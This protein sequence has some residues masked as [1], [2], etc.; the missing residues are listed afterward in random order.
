MKKMVSLKCMWCVLPLCILF[1]VTGLTSCSSDPDTDTESVWVF[2]PFFKPAKTKNATEHKTRVELIAKEELPD[3]LITIVNN[4][5]EVFSSTAVFTTQ[6][7]GKKIYNVYYLGKSNYNSD[8]QLIDFY[9]SD[10]TPVSF[11]I[12]SGDYIGFFSTEWCLIYCAKP[13]FYLRQMREELVDK[14]DLPAWL[15]GEIDK[16]T[17]VIVYILK[18]EEQQIYYVYGTHGQSL[19]IGGFFADGTRCSEEDLRKYLGTTDWCL[20]YLRE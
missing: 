17:A 11:S 16:W 18:Y 14:E 19:F 10:G 5:E 13:A 2:D 7:E 3:W 12:K 8:F 9:Y 1:L 6:W 15:V 20:I 4:R